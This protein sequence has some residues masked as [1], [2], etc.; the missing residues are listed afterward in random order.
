MLTLTVEIEGKNE[1]DLELALQE[2]T[3]LVGEGY[4]SGN[5]SNDTGS[6][7]F[8]VTGEEEAPDDDETLC[9][10]EEEARAAGYQVITFPDDPGKFYW[11]TSEATA[12]TGADTIE[13]AWLAACE[14]AEITIA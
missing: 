3:R 9:P 12:L 1:G 2:V 5:N 4:T 14:D 6:F 10:G 7:R 13:A 8:T 11:N